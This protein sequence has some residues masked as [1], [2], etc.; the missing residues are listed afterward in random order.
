MGKCAHELARKGGERI[1]TFDAIFDTPCHVREEQTVARESNHTVDK[2]KFT[3][4]IKDELPFAVKI[5]KQ[6]ISQEDLE[7]SYQPR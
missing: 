2:S 3:I 6:A 4:R 7:M 5:S 1:D